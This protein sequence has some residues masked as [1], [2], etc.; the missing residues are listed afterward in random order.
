MDYKPLTLSFQR[1]EFSRKCRYTWSEIGVWITANYLFEC[2]Q[3]L[4]MLSWNYRNWGHLRSNY[5]DQPTPAR[6]RL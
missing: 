3:Q 4:F 6:G 5:P 2:R 1:S